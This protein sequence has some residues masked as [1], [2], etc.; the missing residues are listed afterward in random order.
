KN[1]IMVHF[2]V[3]MDDGHH[4]LFKGYRVQHNN[5]L[6]PYKGG[7][8]FHKDVH[9]DDVKSL[10]LLMTLKNSLVRVPLG[11]GKGGVKCDPRA[12]SA[13]ELERVTRRFTAAI[14]NDIGPDY[15]IPA[16]DVGTNAQM[17]AWIA[18]TYQMSSTERHHEGMRVVTGKPI[19]IGGSLGREKATGQGVVDVLCEM[20]PAM[21]VPID[22]MTVAI[23]GYGNVGSWAG[24]ILQKMGARIVAVQDHGGQL[25][26]EGGFDCDALAAHVREHGSIAGFETSN[27]VT[28]SGHHTSRGAEVISDEDFYRTPCDVFIPAALEQMINARTADWLHCRVVIEAANGPC[29]PEGNAILAS[30]GIEVIP[31]ILANAGGVTVSYFEWVQ[32]KSCVIWDEETVDRELNRH[33]CM[34]ARRTMLAKQ[35]YQVDLRTAAYAASLEHI[36]KVYLTRG[37]FP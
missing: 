8:R 23:Q 11:G 18:D 21:G 37:I 25:R 31:D 34:A 22:G 12:L 15:D 32:N 5:A 36:G 9:L 35:K 4:R 10:A 6:G 17:M 2:P 7:L 13:G 3:R 1:E 19:E 30:K 26:N 27:S 20:L 24:R 29:T 14:I 28:G 16:P 33:M